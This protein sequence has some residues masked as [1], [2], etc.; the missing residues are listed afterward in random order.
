MSTKPYVSHETRAA[1]PDLDLSDPKTW[2]G[3]RACLSQSA[4]KGA[5]TRKRNAEKEAAKFQPVTRGK[6]IRK[7]SAL[8]RV[9]PTKKVTKDPVL[10]G[11]KV[12]DILTDLVYATDNTS[13]QVTTSTMEF[14]NTYK[15]ATSS[16]YQAVKSIH[17]FRYFHPVKVQRGSHWNY[18]WRKDVLTVGKVTTASCVGCR[19]VI[20]VEVGD[21]LTE[22]EFVPLSL[23]GHLASCELGVH[24]GWTLNDEGVHSGWTVS[25]HS[26]W[27]HSA[28]TSALG[29]SV[30]SDPKPVA[31]E[32]PTPQ[33]NGF[34]W[35]RALASADADV[36]GM[37]EGGYAG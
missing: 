3:W 16:F 10:V 7:D 22:S 29:S 2:V 5:E 35:E 9:K 33:E 11:L 18:V 12:R 31:V 20:Y 34:F 24:S 37:E 30:D 25:V 28:S 13:W 21:L 26:G 14:C 27:T 32:P 17:W 1:H 6:F 19:R 36:A 15:Y 4:K 23:P 8:F